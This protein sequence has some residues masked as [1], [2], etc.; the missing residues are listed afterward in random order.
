MGAFFGAFGKT[1]PIFTIKYQQD[2]ATVGIRPCTDF[3]AL[4]VFLRGL[5]HFEPVIF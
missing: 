3:K 1:E 4:Q 5:F 2:I